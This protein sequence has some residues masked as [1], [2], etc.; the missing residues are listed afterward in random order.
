[1]SGN[2]YTKIFPIPVRRSHCCGS[3]HLQHRPRAS[4]GPKL[5]PSCQTSTSSSSQSAQSKPAHHCQPR[6][7]IP[8]QIAAQA[9]KSSC[10]PVLH[11][12]QLRPANPAATTARVISGPYPHPAASPRSLPARVIP[13][14]NPQPTPAEPARLVPTPAQTINFLQ[15]D[16]R[17][18]PRGLPA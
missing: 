14:P 18:P 2:L 9:S 10:Q 13:E 5:Q 4:I 15:Q 1:M 16:Y 7:V 11:M 6:S 17:L 12:Y 3:I 8:A